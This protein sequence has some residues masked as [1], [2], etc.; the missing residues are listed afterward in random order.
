MKHVEFVENA[1]FKSYI[2]WLIISVF[3]AHD[4]LLMHKV[5]AMASFQ[6][7][8]QVVTDRHTEQLL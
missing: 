7:A 8:V 2:S 6:S 4:E 5:T 3:F 1:L